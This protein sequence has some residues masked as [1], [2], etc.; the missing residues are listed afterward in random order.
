MVCLLAYATAQMDLALFGYAIPSIR[1][2]FGLSLSGV[3]IIVSTAFIIGGMLIVWLGMWT[4]RVG[5]RVM[6]QFSLIGSSILIALHSIVPNPATLAALRGT[7]IAVGGLSYPITGAV[8]TEEFPARYRGLFLGFLQIGYPLGWALASLWAAWLLGA[9]G[10]RILFLVG[11]VSLP[12]AWL[13]N[14]V[15]HEPARFLENRAGRSAGDV[16]RARELL[17]PGI[18]R[19]ALLLFSAQFLFVWAY[20]GSI[21]LFPSYLSAARGFASFEF[22]TLIGAG[23]AIGILGYI[24][25]AVI[26]EF[27]I[28][29]RTTVVIWTLLGA[30]MFQLVVWFT[31][32]YREL[33]IIYGL[34]SMFFYGASAVKFAYLAEVFPTRLRAT[35]MASCG[36]LAVILGSAAGPMM[37][38]VAVERF[39]W[40]LGYSVV[41]GVPLV[42]AGFLYLFLTP[43]PSGLEVEEVESLLAGK[44]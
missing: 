42:L 20:A 36:S 9:Y 28:T 30:V 29:R 27:V 13:V 25:A 43:V 2:D 24:L 6:F 18:R 22:S 3:M 44:S 10:W 41:V 16:P 34:M 31:H 11:L 8:I 1:K 23:N 5:R 4:D 7:S 15:I 35:A 32:D 38:S 33:L 12:I 39:G 17:A 21:F 14:R 40:N 26:G 19:R 37:V